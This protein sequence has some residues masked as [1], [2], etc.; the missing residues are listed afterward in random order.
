[1]KAAKETEYCELAGFQHVYLEDSYVLGIV[2]T[3]GGLQFMLDLVLLDNHPRY[4]APRSGER[5]CYQ[6]AVLRFPDVDRSEWAART[7]VPARDQSCEV[8]YGNIDRMTYDGARYQVTGDWGSVQ[9]R[10]AQPLLELLDEPDVSGHHSRL[11]G[12]R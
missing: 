7:V 8:D 2:E 10:S 11:D 12:L 4:R 5:Y 3:A 9:L 1:M 6:R